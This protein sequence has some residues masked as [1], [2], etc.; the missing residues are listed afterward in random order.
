MDR[1]LH[2]NLNGIQQNYIA[3]FLWLHNEPDEDIIAEIERIYESGIR[4]V[5]LESRTHEE[6]CREDWW[7]DIKL[8]FDKC[9]ELGMNAWILDDKHFPTGHSN[10]IFKEKYKH[11]QA[12]G[13][14]EQHIDVVGP[15]TDGSAIAECW[16]ESDEDEIVKIS[17]LKHIPNTERYSEIIDITDGL[18]DGMVYFDLPEGMWRIVFMIKTKRGRSEDNQ[19]IYSLKRCMSLIISISGNT[20][21][22]PS[23]A[24]FPMSRLFPTTRQI[25]L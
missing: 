4:S 11:L 24:S 23:L 22:K 1:R 10:G 14:T 12:F 9:K 15:V 8:I 21:E 20:S 13:I 5:C 2:E 16:L 17:A 19:L 25:P 3:P 7:S 18:S 6:F